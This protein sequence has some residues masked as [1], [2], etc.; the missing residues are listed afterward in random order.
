MKR[1]SNNTL[2]A[3]RRRATAFA[4]FIYEVPVGSRFTLYNR[5]GAVGV[6]NPGTLAQQD[7]VHELSCAIDEEWIKPSGSHGV[8]IRI[9]P[10]RSA[11]ARL[12]LQQ[13]VARIVDAE[14]GVDRV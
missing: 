1:N 9:G 5:Q 3:R 7:C 4:N 10:A 11:Y 8:Y 13:L 6:C 12:Q 14:A 2:A